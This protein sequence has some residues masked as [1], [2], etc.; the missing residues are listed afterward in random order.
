MVCLCIDLLWTL[1]QCR[2]ELKHKFCN[3]TKPL[4]NFT[5]CYC[6]KIIENPGS[7][8]GSNRT[9]SVELD[10]CTR[11]WYIRQQCFKWGCWNICISCLSLFNGNEN[12]WPSR[13]F[14]W[15]PYLSW[16][17]L[18]GGY[19]FSRI[20]EARNWKVVRMGL[21]PIRLATW[22]YQLACKI[23][24]KPS[25]VKLPFLGHLPSFSISHASCIR[26][27]FVQLDLASVQPA[28]D[29]VV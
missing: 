11:R 18:F 10:R 15:D 8:R 23:L 21:K 2:H 27:A 28:E 5:V 26:H 1:I 7:S 13:M 6:S 3:I 16:S 24:C 20:W 22:F 14:G 19:A 9:G 29:L 4:W 17:F 25:L 12:D